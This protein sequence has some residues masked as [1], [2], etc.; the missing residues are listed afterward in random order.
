VAER[1]VPEVVRERDGLGQ[2]L[3]GRQRARD[4]ARDL[5]HFQRVR[6][7]RAEHVAFVIHEDLRLVL[8]TPERRRMDHSVAIAL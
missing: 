4:R 1:R 6:Q 7:A 5:R 2:V 8:E 3:V